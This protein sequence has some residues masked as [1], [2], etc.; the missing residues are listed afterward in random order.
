MCLDGKEKTARKKMEE[1][2]RTGNEENKNKIDFSEHFFFIM[3]HERAFH[4]GQG[5]DNS[6]ECFARKCARTD[7]RCDGENLKR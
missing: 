2:V 7:G 6:N 4:S 5:C 3:I 1:T